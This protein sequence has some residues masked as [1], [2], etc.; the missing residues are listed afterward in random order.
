MADK[1]VY[2]IFESQILDGTYKQRNRLNK[3]I[4]QNRTCNFFIKT[5]KHITFYYYYESEFPSKSIINYY[6]MCF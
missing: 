3:T 1:L 4:L 6:F 2:L 5:L